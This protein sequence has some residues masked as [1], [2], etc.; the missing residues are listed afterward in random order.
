MFTQN[1]KI[2]T[3]FGFYLPENTSSTFSKLLYKLY[4]AVWIVI[5][6]SALGFKF[7]NLF[8]EDLSTLSN[9]ATSM[10]LYPDFSCVYVKALNIIDKRNM[11]LEVR[12]ILSEGN[13]VCQNES[14][15][16]A[17]AKYDK[18]CRFFFCLIFTENSQNLIRI[19]HLEMLF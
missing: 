19:F 4:S 12:R 7:F 10:F 17:K 14:E 2:F 9:I 1:F 15:M 8:F 16:M 5:I 3:Y 18:V 6:G 13:C 11:F